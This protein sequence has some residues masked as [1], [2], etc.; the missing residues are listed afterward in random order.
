MEENSVDEI[1]LAAEVGLRSAGKRDAASLVREAS[2]SSPA[3]ATKI[4]KSYH[5]SE[6][7]EPVKL[8]NDEALAFFID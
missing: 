2:T 8:S 7:K 5:F 3:R 6:T 1:V 4:K